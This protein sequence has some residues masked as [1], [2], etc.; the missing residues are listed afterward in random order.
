MAPC[1]SQKKN[2]VL[3]LSIKLNTSKNEIV[4][5]STWLKAASNSE[6]EVKILN[7]TLLS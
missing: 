7:N 1:V 4:C 3:H 5:V 6:A 2:A